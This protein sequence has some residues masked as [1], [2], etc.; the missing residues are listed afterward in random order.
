MWIQFIFFIPHNHNMLNKLDWVECQPCCVHWARTVM[1]ASS[2]SV[3]H[4]ERQKVRFEYQQQLSTRRAFHLLYHCEDDAD[5]GRG[6]RWLT[7]IVKEPIATE[8]SR[9]LSL[10]HLIF[11]FLLPPPGNLTPLDCLR[12]PIW[13]TSRQVHSALC[14][15]TADPAW[16]GIWPA[17]APAARN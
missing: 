3:T 4:T 5:S 11:T 8:V 15:A 6:R 7:A 2:L 14:L 17:H 9:S 10:Y 16:P 1:T 13:D 12:R